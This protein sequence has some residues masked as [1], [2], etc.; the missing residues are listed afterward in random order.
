MALHRRRPGHRQGQPHGAALPGRRAGR[1][2]LSGVRYLQHLDGGR[3]HGR[4]GGPA[5]LDRGGP[6]GGPGQ[7]ARGLL[8]LQLLRHQGQHSQHRHDAEPGPV[9][10]LGDRGVQL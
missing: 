1:Q 4:G 7:D 6:P 5:Q 9:C 2:A 8:H 10:Q 3:G